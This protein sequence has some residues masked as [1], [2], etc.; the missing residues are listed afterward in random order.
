MCTI[1]FLYEIVVSILKYYSQTLLH[2]V[3]SS[4]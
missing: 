4:S 3:L 2:I 1:T